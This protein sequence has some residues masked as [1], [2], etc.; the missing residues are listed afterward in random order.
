MAQN[1]ST[2][3]NTGFTLLPSASCNVDIRLSDISDMRVQL[4][5]TYA[6]TSALTGL[7]VNLFAGMGG[8]DPA[9]NAQTPIPYVL[10][11]PTSQNLSTVPV[12]GGNSESLNA[13]SGVV[14]PAGGSGTPQTTRTVFFLASPVIEWSNWMRMTI[15]NRDTVNSCTVALLADI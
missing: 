3:I 4:V 11:N 14:Q 13:G 15:Y 6:A 9:E 1:I 2:Y 12:F 8:K 7:N 5:Q 10:S